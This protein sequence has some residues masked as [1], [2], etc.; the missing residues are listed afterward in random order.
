VAKI[1]LTEER[2]QIIQGKIDK[3]IEARRVRSNP[4]GNVRQSVL[5]C[6]QNLSNP[7]LIAAII[8]EPPED[9]EAFVQFMSNEELKRKVPSLLMR[10]TL[11]PVRPGFEIEFQRVLAVN[12]NVDDPDW[13]AGAKTVES[14]LEIGEALSGG[15]SSEKVALIVGRISTNT[16]P[17]KMSI[18]LGWLE[19]YVQEGKEFVAWL[20]WYKEEQRR[21]SKGTSWND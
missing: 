20:K 15:E 1:A 18:V 3:E 17:Q 8:D 9:I 10:A 7:K 16:T 21:A 13:V 6:L 12:V 4:T 14:L 2:V 5:S 11:L 19:N